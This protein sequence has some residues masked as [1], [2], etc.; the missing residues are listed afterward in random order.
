[1]RWSPVATGETPLSAFLFDNQTR[2]AICGELA[3][4]FSFAPAVSKKKWRMGFVH[5]YKLYTFGLQPDVIPPSAMRFGGITFRLMTNLICKSK[6]G[7]LHKH[8]APSGRE[9]ARVARL[10]E[11]AV[12]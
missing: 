3:S 2:E 12:L 5:C 9:L 10:R 8:K 6:V 7:N 11:N 4:L 1:M